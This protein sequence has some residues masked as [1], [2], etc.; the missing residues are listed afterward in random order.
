MLAAI[1]T[2]RPNIDAL[3]LERL[4]PEHG[5]VA[6]PLLALPHF[7]SPNISLAV[8]LE[9]GFDA[10]LSRVSG[11]RKKKKHRSQMRK[12]EAAGGYRRIFVK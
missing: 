7:P 5:G 2:A 9:G 8:S 10:L 6:N 3:V 12:F 1:R 11:K 4:L